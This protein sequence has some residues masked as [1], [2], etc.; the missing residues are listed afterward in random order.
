[1]PYDCMKHYE[2]ATEDD[3]WS[4]VGN[5]RTKSFKVC[6]TWELS[7]DVLSFENWKKKELVDEPVCL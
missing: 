7:A 1:M 6:G 3:L 4:F 5:A 2:P